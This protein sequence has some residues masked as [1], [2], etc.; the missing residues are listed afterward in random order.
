MSST[1]PPE[2]GSLGIGSLERKLF[3]GSLWDTDVCRQTDADRKANPEKYITKDRMTSKF[4]DASNFDN[5]IDDHKSSMKTLIQ[6]IYEYNLRNTDL[7][8][9]QLELLRIEYGVDWRD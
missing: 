1:T 8:S 7:T 9:Q 3:T 5:R 6:N 4:V 2:P